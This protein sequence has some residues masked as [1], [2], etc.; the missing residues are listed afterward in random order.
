MEDP[1]IN[2]I[3]PERDFLGRGWSFPVAF[4]K[5][6]KEVT[7]ETGVPD[8]EQSIINILTTTKGERVMRPFYGANVDDYIFEPLQATTATVL[9]DLI[10]KAISRDE[11]RVNI[12]E[13]DVDF[14]QLPSEGR[15]DITINYTIRAT[16]SRRN[17]VYPF[18]LNEG[19]DLDQ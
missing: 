9:A 3:T 8:I 16:N 7:M 1:I 12:D 17:I 11:P 13:G 6:A 4:N 15:I 5:A 2:V 14:E 18:Y 10:R 19:T